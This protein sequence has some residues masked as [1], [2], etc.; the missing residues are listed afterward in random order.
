[1]LHDVKSDRTISDGSADIL[2]QD[3]IFYLFAITEM[4]PDIIPAKSET[5][6]TQKYSQV[7]RNRKLSNIVNNAEKIQE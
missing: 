2:Y 7:T 5:L 1:M 6:N 4:F 3:T